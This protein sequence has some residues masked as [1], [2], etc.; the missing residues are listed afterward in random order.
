M[1]ADLLLEMS[2][3][4]RQSEEGRKS[5]ALYSVVAPVPGFAGWHDD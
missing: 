2:E 5:L 1:N 3:L 4:R